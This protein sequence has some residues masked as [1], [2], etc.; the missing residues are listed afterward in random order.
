[1]GVRR[2][3]RGWSGG[4]YANQMVIG[5]WVAEF[6]EQEWRVEEGRQGGRG[7]FLTSSPN[8]PVPSEVCRFLS[9]AL[10]DFDGPHPR[11]NGA[12]VSA[13]P[14]APLQGPPISHPELQLFPAFGASSAV[15]TTNWLST[16]AWRPLFCHCLGDKWPFP[17]TPPCRPSPGCLLL[18]GRGEGDLQP[19]Q[20]ALLL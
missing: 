9:S 15:T 2:G 11:T 16:A 19:F 20:E 8:P 7:K 14:M 1:M 5:V 17:C 3:T 12:F 18:V 6:P 10:N 4:V 13:R